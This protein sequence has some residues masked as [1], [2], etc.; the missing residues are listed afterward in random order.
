MD[1][2]LLFSAPA[3]PKELVKRCVLSEALARQTMGMLCFP[4]SMKRYHQFSSAVPEKHGR[5][6]MKPFN[7]HDDRSK[8]ADLSAAL[9]FQSG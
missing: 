1:S 6:I 8:D 3:A 9:A 4:L 7:R 5:P 2:A